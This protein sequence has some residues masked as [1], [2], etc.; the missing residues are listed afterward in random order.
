MTKRQLHYLEERVT[1]NVNL[2]VNQI[3]RSWRFVL[4]SKLET[5]NIFIVKKKSQ[6]LGNNIDLKFLENNQ[7]SIK[8][9][10]NL[11]MSSLYKNRNIIY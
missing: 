7:N 11:G 6:N 3:K 1:A 5:L 9:N 8:Q 10:K 2:K 4:Y